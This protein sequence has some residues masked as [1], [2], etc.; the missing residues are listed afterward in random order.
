MVVDGRLTVSGA[1]G[2]SN[3]KINFIEIRGGSGAALTA[4]AIYLPTVTHTPMPTLVPPTATATATGGTPAPTTTL[5]PTMTPPPP[6]TPPP[7]SGNDLVVFGDGLSWGWENW[8]WGGTYN[9]ANIAPTQAGSS[10]VAVSYSDAWGALYL[11][12]RTP[13]Y[14]VNYG[15]VRFWAHGG[16]AGG[17]QI[18]AQLVDG[19]NTFM[20]YAAASFTL[21]ANRWTEVYLPLSQFNHPASIGGIIF[22]DMAGGAQPTYYIDSITMSPSTPTP[23]P[24]EPPGP[25]DPLSRIQY[26]GQNMFLHGVNAAWWNF[27]RDFGGGPYGGGLSDTL[28]NSSGGLDWGS[29]VTQR[30]A[31]LPPANVHYVKWWMFESNPTDQPNGPFQILRDASG[32]P[33]GI[34]PNVYLDIDAAL[35]AA[36][37][38]DLYYEMALF[39]RP[40]YLPI[41]WLT[42][43]RADLI[44]ALQPLFARYANNPRMMT[45]SI[46]VE[47]DWDIWEGNADLILSRAFVQA[48]TM[49]IHQESNA[50]VTVNAAMV[51]GL[52]NWQGLGLDFYS[53]SWYDYM[54]SN[55]PRTHDGEG[56]LWCA[57]CTTYDEIRQRY[58]LDK[59]LVIGEFYAGDTANYVLPNSNGGPFERFE[60]WYDK[61]YAGSLAWCLFPER[62]MSYM[63]VNFTYYGQFGN[64]HGDMGPR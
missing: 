1:S 12:S 53:T 43:Y 17:Q 54:N 50:L 37:Q 19:S 55:D 48:M 44:N 42:T 63:A 25:V 24:T 51:D 3:N 2:A 46:F 18:R 27:S 64:R 5:P 22:Q 20:P 61:G 30:L 38:F 7:P 47:P 58:A 11:H 28:L 52:P 49:A 60:A 26:N 35:L 39:V 6:G 33:T 56:G 59:P 32:R 16:S 13:L 14:G 62:T 36:E 23:A 29:V 31:L 34:D 4:T 41:S 15:G 21:A 10:S 57:L 8:S 9:L 40:N 45:Y